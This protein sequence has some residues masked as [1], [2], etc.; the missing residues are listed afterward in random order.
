MTE[1]NKAGVG[2]AISTVAKELGID[3]YVFL[4]F[5][6]DRVVGLADIPPSVITPF[7]KKLIMDKLA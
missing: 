5:D 2:T 4:Y 6:K 7:L 1:I 3:G